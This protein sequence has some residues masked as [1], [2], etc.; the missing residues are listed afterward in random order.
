MSFRGGLCFVRGS[1]EVRSCGVSGNAPTNENLLNKMD[2]Q[3]S[4][5][6]GVFAFFARRVRHAPPP[7]CGRGS[8]IRFCS[9]FLDFFSPSFVPLGPV[10][11]K[12]VPL[13]C[14]P[15]DGWVSGRRG[16]KTSGNV[17]FR[18][19]HC[20]ERECVQSLTLGTWLSSSLALSRHWLLLTWI[21]VSFTGSYSHS[22]LPLR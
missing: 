1:H 8:T 18:S 13:G 20:W 4:P 16:Q 12:C 14:C 6:R 17:T 19:S 2:R 15:C 21:R 10:V 3:Q 22:W 7:S 5:T 11:S 9:F